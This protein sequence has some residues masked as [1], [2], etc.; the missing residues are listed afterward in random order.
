MTNKEFYKSVKPY[1]T[2]KGTDI[3][4]IDQNKLVSD[5]KEIAEIFNNYF[6]N[7]VKIPTRKVPKNRRHDFPP[8][9][10]NISVVLQIIKQYRKHPSILCIKGNVKV[11]GNFKFTNSLGA[12][13]VFCTP[14]GP[15][16]FEH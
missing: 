11:D 1:I 3:I 2:N 8:E 16:K 7:I 14:R 12:C 15:Q 5:D 9:I 10:S 6:A 4:L 13:V